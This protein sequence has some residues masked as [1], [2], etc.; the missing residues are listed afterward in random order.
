M[1][2]KYCNKE[3]KNKNSLIN[4]ERLCKSNPNKKETNFKDYNK[5]LSLGLIKGTNHFIKAKSNGKTIIVSKETREKFSRSMTGRK[6]SE[7]TKKR[8]SEIRIKYLK[9]HPDKVPY[10]LNHYSKGDSY[11]E[12]Y[13]E[14][15][16]LKENIP[17]KKKKQIGIYQLDF[18]NEELMLYVEIDGD[19]HYLDKR[20]VDSDIR[21]SK[22]LKDLGWKE[23]RIKWSHYQ[24]LSY[25]DKNKII[26]E[27]KSLMRL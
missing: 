3:C 1:F 2:C 19:Q 13:F 20:I 23:F 15:L 17:L 10:L 8:I 14:E 22:F 5:K 4:N 18:Y 26:L 7:E 9:D 11:P 16:F 6:H 12:K 25:E 21:R 24:T 27:I